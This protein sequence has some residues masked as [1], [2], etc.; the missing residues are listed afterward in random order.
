MQIKI[1]IKSK[2]LKR[3]QQKTREQYIKDVLVKLEE[4][5][6]NFQLTVQK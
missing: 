6:Q 5:L 4:E 1:N 3:K 2:Y